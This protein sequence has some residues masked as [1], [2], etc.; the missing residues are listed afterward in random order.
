MAPCDNQNFPTRLT[1]SGQFSNE[2]SL[3]WHVL[4]TLHGPNEVKLPIPEGLSESIGYLIM[5]FVT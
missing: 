1:N 4:T 2:L 5:Y 3:V